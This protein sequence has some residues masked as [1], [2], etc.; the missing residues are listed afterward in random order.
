MLARV[1][2]RRF[3]GGTLSS[4]TRLPS[5]VLRA[6][7][8]LTRAGVFAYR[9]PDG[10]IRRELRLPAEVMSDAVLDGLRGAVLTLGHPALPVTRETAAD[11]AVGHVATDVRVDGSK[12]RATLL[13]HDGAAIEAMEKGTRQLSCGY[14]CD[15]DETP[16]VTIGI[17]GVPDGL[18]Y[19]GVQRALEY[20]HAA[21]VDVGRAGPDVA[22][23]L[24]GWR[25]DGVESVGVRVDN[26]YSV[27]ERDGKF[28]VVKS[29]TGEVVGTHP[30]RDAAERQVRALYAAEDRDDDG[31]RENVGTAI[32]SAMHD[33]NRTA[34]EVGAAIGLGELEVD[35]I[36]RG[37][38][39]PTRE[40]ARSLEV[41]LDLAPET[42]SVLLPERARS[43]D[44]AMKYT[45]QIDGVSFEVECDERTHQALTRA[46]A[47][48]A[49]SLAVAEKAR[50]DSLS[51]VE[52]LRARADAAEEKATKAE[53]ALAEA[54]SP[55]ATRKAVAA[56]LGLERAAASVLGETKLDA[57][58]DEAIMRAVVAKASP[59]ATEK[60]KDCSAEYLRA[61]FDLAI[62][63]A[64]K[65]TVA[66][67]RRI[68]HD[69]RRDDGDDYEKARADW[70]RKQQDA[71]R[72]PL[73][74][75]KDAKTA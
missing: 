40:Q 24:D 54:S 36:L 50:A 12:V 68:A 19:D 75:S 21:L 34:G 44:A 63:Q 55:D 53:K 37:W 29:E 10:S 6:D 2:A 46:A 60:I 22:A 59:D 67:A 49:E 71:W 20:N 57:M 61:R 52:K 3:D 17:E 45:F 72:Q 13:V 27:E 70:M 48:G 56:R 4:P 64:P 18:A 31:Y 51:E 7:A 5:G 9:S 74:A 28:V 42:L 15:V 11:V 66:D 8:Y 69:G 47:K 39:L 30:S 32:W 62:E 23:R 16:G 14:L 25:T 65:A 41:F 1:K 35:S 33:A 38:R 58:D 26:P 73:T 43:E